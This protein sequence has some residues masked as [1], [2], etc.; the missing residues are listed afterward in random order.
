[1]WTRGR[2]ANEY[3]PGLFAIAVDSYEKKRAM[4][5]WDQLVTVGNSKKAKEEDA[6]R[7]GL[8]YDA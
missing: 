8:G 4:S 6:I 7:S 5:M 2:F 1:M 3:V